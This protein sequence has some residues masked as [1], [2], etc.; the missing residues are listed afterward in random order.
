MKYNRCSPALRDALARVFHGHVCG[1][2]PRALAKGDEMTE[3]ALRKTFC[4]LHERWPHAFPKTPDKRVP[5]V[6]DVRKQ[7]IEQLPEDAPVSRAD[8]AK[9]LAHWCLA[10]TYLRAL[11]AQTHR[12]GLDGKPVEEVSVAHK[13]EAKRR[14]ARDRERSVPVGETPTTPNANKPTLRLGKRA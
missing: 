4:Y 7:I 6:R 2:L 14:M 3:E 5:L 10:D 8:I 11:I 1:A 9:F 13:Q 12:I